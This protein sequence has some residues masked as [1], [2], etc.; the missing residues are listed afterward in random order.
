MNPIEANRRIFAAI[1]VD[2]AANARP[3]APWNDSSWANASTMPST[4]CADAALSCG[5]ASSLENTCR[6]SSRHSGRTEITRRASS[7]TLACGELSSG[8]T[9]GGARGLGCN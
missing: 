3:I 9:I 7:L 8:T 2:S 6:T 4:S 5:S 1:E